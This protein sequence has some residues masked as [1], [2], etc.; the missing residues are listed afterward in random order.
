MFKDELGDTGTNKDM[1]DGVETAPASFEE[2]SINPDL[3][4]REGFASDAEYQA[5]IATLGGDAP[6]GG[7]VEEPLLVS[8]GHAL[9]GRLRELR[10]ELENLRARLHVIQHQAA[11]VV[12][13]NVRWADASA[14][15]QLGNQPWLKL[16]GAMA[17]TFVVTRGIMRLPLGAV[18]TTALPLV[19]A[20]MN[21][22][23]AR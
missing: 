5:Y 14:H 8:D 1:R 4:R 12:T 3:I 19:A 11:T 9:E 23:L 6:V 15:A 10:E 21:R 13:E 22:N 2:A 7:T 16:A 20:A 18:A 17:A